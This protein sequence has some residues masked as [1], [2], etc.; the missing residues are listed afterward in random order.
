MRV[1]S[2]R[3]FVKAARKDALTALKYSGIR[4]AVTDKLNNRQ[5]EGYAQAKLSGESMP[6]LI[7]GRLDRANENTSRSF[8]RAIQAGVPALKQ[9]DTVNNAYQ[10]TMDKLGGPS[11]KKFNEYQSSRTGLSAKSSTKAM[12][13]QIK[14]S[15]KR[16]KLRTRELNKKLKNI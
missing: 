13:N 16:K 7:Q 6:D 10:K 4:S 9:F 5:F 3:K 11:Q 15:E 2:A 8:K 14:D 1:P 12:R